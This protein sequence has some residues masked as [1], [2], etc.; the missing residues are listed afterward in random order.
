MSRRLNVYVRA[1]RGDDE[2]AM[3]SLISAGELILE[4]ANNKKL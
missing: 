2:L 1:R 4:E 3:T